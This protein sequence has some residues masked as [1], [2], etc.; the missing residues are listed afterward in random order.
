MVNLTFNL[1]YKT[2]K[3]NPT[4]LQISFMSERDIEKGK[5]KTGIQRQ[6]RERETNRDRTLP[7]ES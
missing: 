7:V 1:F 3:Q 5:R 6:M 4:L 2:I